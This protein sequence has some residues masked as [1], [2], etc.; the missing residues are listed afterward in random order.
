MTTEEFRLRIAQGE[1]SRTQFK[2]GPIGVSKLAAGVIAFE[3]MTGF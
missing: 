2:R 3:R 1:D